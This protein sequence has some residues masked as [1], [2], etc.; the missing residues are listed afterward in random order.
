MLVGPI[1]RG[2]DSKQA[3]R[4]HISP[5]N[6]L[7]Y[8]QNR[9]RV[10]HGGESLPKNIQ[11]TSNESLIKTKQRISRNGYTVIYCLR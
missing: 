4:D 3:I 1:A 7:V 6:Q 8:E 2:F 5:E 10:E 9:S 11:I